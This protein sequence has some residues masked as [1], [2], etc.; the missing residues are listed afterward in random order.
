[1][2]RADGSHEL[3]ADETLAR[4]TGLDVGDHVTLAS[5]T[6]EDLDRAVNEG[7]RPQTEPVDMEIVGVA[8]FAEDLAPQR[9]EDL[10]G[11]NPGGMLHASGAASG[12]V[13][14]FANYGVSP[15]VRLRDGTG[16]ADEL[17][18][19]LSSR[20]SDRFFR[21]DPVVDVNTVAV[22]NVI[23]NERRATLAF[24]AI[25]AAAG[26]AFGGLAL[27]RQLRREQAGAASLT[28]IGMARRDLVAG[29]VLRGATVALPAAALAVLTTIALSPL[30]P[31]GVARRAEPA[32]GVHVDGPVLALVVIAVLALVG[33][34]S[35]L[36]PVLAARRHRRRGLLG[37]DGRPSG[38]PSAL[39]AVVSDLGA[40]ARAGVMLGQGSWPRASAAVAAIAVTAVVAAS[41]L[42]GSLDR[43]VGDPVRYGAWWDVSMGDYSDPDAL[44]TGVDVIRADPDIVEAAGVFDQ[45]EVATIDGRAVPLMAFEPYVGDAEPVVSDGR[46]PM[47]DDEIAIG[48]RLLH[49]L[50]VDIGDTVLLEPAEGAVGVAPRR[51]TIVGE[52]VLDNPISTSHGVGE[53][54]VVQPAVMIEFSGAAVAQEI[55][56][57]FDASKDRD[58][59][60]RQL[61]TTFDGAIRGTD[62]PDDIRNLDR[63]RA[64][65]WLIAVVVALLALA[66][67]THADVTMVSQ[68][69]GDLALLAALGLTPTQRRRVPAWASFL[70]MS[71]AAV[72]GAVAG[73]V[74]G[75]VVWR[76]LAGGIDI[77]SEPAVPLFVPVVA[78]AALLLTGQVVTRL[79]TRAVARARPADL[80]RAE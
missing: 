46:G 6:L 38:R 45:A 35:A 11:L 72:V 39:A 74:V 80:L 40:P 4:A 71:V 54:A 34:V 52:A 76:A 14:S 49:E 75:R 44:A 28:A 31:I 77:V 2:P 19:E 73:A 56:A 53:T 37:A 32:L 66:T 51:M 47:R 57:R 13:G 9:T 65:P 78:A 48:R 3:L 79:A 23:D 27:A 63:L 24:A 36:A 64:L 18:R 5:W 58:A 12:V 7:L 25:A 16:G 42:V 17:Q 61:A 69:R 70:L 10:S 30:G 22:N 41:V 43:V 59:V 60:V 21:I 20:W 8:R 29:S 68:H 26:A 55:V 33:A 50:D 15:F 62:P 1:M 67:M